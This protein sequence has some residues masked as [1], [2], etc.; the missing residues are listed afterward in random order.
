MSKTFIELINKTID[1]AMRKNK[2]VICYGLGTTDPKGIFGSTIGLQKKYGNERVFDVPASENA[3]T[4]MAIGASMKGTISILNHQRLDF[5][6]LS[7]D[8][9]INNAAKWYYTFGSTVNIPI[10]IRMITGRG[11]GQGP[12]HSQN[13]QAIFNHIPGLKVIMPSTAND[14]STDLLSAIFDP[15]PVIFIENR[16][17]HNSTTNVKFDP[18]IKKIP[19]HRKLSKGNDLTIISM[20]YMT[21]ESIKAVNILKKLYDINCELIDL[22]SI[23][24]IKLSYLKRSIEKTKNLLLVD[25]GSLNGCVSNSILYRLIESGISFNSKPEILA[26]PDIPEPTSHFMTKKFYNNYVNI[27][28]K[29]LNILKINKN[30]ID[31]SGDNDMHDTPGPWFKG[32]F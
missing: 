25:T 21:I 14:I 5:A 6:L 23:S 31:Q 15:N 20:S 28:N 1:L 18:K 9:I 8:Q 7:L 12:T 29:V 32:P 16:W 26:M 13:L 11:W 27:V 10:T 4:G 30:F 17:L 3:L 22:V 2:N 19:Y 24:P